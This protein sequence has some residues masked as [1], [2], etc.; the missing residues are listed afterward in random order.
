MK[1]S[2]LLV[3]A[4][5]A[6]F[7]F[8]CKKGD[9]DPALSLLSRKARLVGDWNLVEQEK[10]VVNDTFNYQNWYSDENTEKI[11]I[12]FYGNSSDSIVTIRTISENKLS[13]NKDG[14]W[15][16]T[17][18]YY[19]L[20]KG[21]FEEFNE[22]Q[23]GDYVYV[24]SGNW[25]FSDKYKEEYENKERL[26]LEQL[27]LTI[28][29]TK[30]HYEADYFDPNFPDYNEDLDDYYAEKISNQ[31]ENIRVYDLLRLAKNEM[32]WTEDKVSANSISD[33]SITSTYGKSTEV[34]TTWV[35]N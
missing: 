5:V 29:R 28:S 33:G 30:S 22:I 13:I 12:L 14:T 15:Q 21:Y 4:F 24:T 23:F 16:R 27:N 34:K 1:K 9:E 7:Q 19:E 31:G 25:S 18:S 2:I 35:K 10:F 20:S 8:S 17:H 11:T 6:A 32:I 3:L 26:I